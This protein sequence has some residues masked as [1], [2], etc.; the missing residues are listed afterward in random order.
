VVRDGGGTAGR[1]RFAAGV[2]EDESGYARAG[3]KL[4]EAARDGGDASRRLG[5]VHHEEHGRAEEFCDLRGGGAVVFE[6]AAVE[7]AHHAFDDGNVR[8]RAGALENGCDAGIVEHPCV[9]VAAGASGGAAVP[10][11]VDVVRPALEGLHDESARAQRGDEAD[12]NGG[13]A[14]AG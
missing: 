7:K 4:F 8:A 1:V 13:F 14:N 9:E 5:N 11:G 2:V 12:D 10:G 3:V 6:I